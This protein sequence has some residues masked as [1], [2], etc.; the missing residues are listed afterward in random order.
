MNGMSKMNLH[1]II[2]T[3]LN[4]VFAMDIALHS[5]EAVHCTVDGEW[6]AMEIQR[7]RQ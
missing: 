6:R 4:P 1:A 5:V 7:N 3:L 2:L